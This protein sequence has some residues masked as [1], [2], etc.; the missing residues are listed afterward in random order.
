MELKSAQRSILITIS[1]LTD[2]EL[3]SNESYLSSGIW[4]SPYP[5]VVSPQTNI[6]FGVES[7][8]Y[9]TIKGF[10]KYTLRYKKKKKSR[11]HNLSLNWDVGLSSSQ[12]TAEGF[13][14]FERSVGNHSDIVYVL[15]S[16]EIFLLQQSKKSK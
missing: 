6:E 8:G 14:V 5:E 10:L 2:F 11:N 13:S 7:H 9:P 3:T 12:F 4:R 1:N 16:D 15:S